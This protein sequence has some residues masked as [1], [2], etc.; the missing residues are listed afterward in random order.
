MT[1]SARLII[2][3]TV[4]AV[5]VVKAQVADICSGQSVPGDLATADVMTRRHTMQDIL[6]SG[7]GTDI[8]IMPR[9][10]LACPNV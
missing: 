1:K 7:K 8:D 4:V 2:G 9:A 6:T 3:V 10:Y 5:G